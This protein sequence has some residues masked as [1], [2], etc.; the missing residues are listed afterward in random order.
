MLAA[1]RA[2]IHAAAS[3]TARSA[4]TDRADVDGSSGSRRKSADLRVLPIANAH[5]SPMRIPTT[6]IQSDSRST[7]PITSPAPAPSAMRTPISPV[8]EQA[9]ES[10]CC[11]RQRDQSEGPRHETKE[12]LSP[13]QPINQRSLRMKLGDRN[14]WIDG[15]DRAP[16]LFCKT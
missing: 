7:M 14:R 13:K 10:N 2:G 16:N 5:G 9:A 8:R 1:W 15:R 11:Q 4:A 6:T 3:A 12:P